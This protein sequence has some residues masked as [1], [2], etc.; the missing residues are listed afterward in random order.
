MSLKILPPH[1]RAHLYL[2]WTGMA[3]AGLG[4]LGFFVSFWRVGSAAAA[5]VDVHADVPVFAYA[6]IAAW[7]LGLG[8]MWYSRRQVDRA[9][10]AKLKAD[11]EAMFV[12]FGVNETSA[13]ETIE[14]TTP[15]GREP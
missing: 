12:E 14:D 13:P 2:F 4:V 11:R 10:A 1:V 3:L 6:S 5:T 9:V 7:V 8:I 15:D